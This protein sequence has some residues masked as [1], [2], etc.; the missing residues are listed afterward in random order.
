[1][2]ILVVCISEMTAVYK[3]N[4]KSEEL[5]FFFKDDYC[6]YLGPGNY[7]SM[8]KRGTR[9]IAPKLKGAHFEG[10]KTPRGAA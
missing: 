3:N 6:E 4:L 8:R 10:L 9:C 1:M 2:V 5:L 7:V